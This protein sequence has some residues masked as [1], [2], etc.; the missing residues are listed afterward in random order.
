MV[1]SKTQNSDVFEA[2]PWSYGT[3]GF[4]VSATL[5]IVPC[6]KWVHI[7][8]KPCTSLAQ[9][10]RTFREAS[11]KDD[12]AQFVEALAYTKERMVVMEANMVDEEQVDA[13]K[14]NRI[15]YWYKPWFYKHVESFFEKGVSDEYIPLR[16]YY[17]RHTK[18]I[19]WELELMCP[20]GNHP[21]FRFLF[22][23]IMPPKVSFLKLTQTKA[24]Q[25][26]YEKEHVIQD[27]L[28]PIDKLADTLECFHENYELYPL[29][30]CPHRHND[31][32]GFLRRPLQPNKDGYEMYV[33]VGAYGVPQ[34]CLDKKPFD[35]V[36]KSR[37]VEAWVAQN[38]GFQMLY[39]D[40]Y[41]TKEEFEGMFDHSHY[42]AMREKLNAAIAF[43]TVFEKVRKHGF[44]LAKYE[45]SKKKNQ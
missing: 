45:A 8:Y 15:S 38:H 43:P 1:C 27:M 34:D 40:S 44:D 32:R 41:Q 3:L 10:D 18:S 7:H 6:K 30:I 13:S 20:L 16:D 17:H 14:T 5:K 33:D 36:D 25:E 2:L 37:K 26:I 21:V 9:G 42:F 35:I 23:M 4:L 12:P 24:L 39:A 29:W 31:E 11:C 28:M 22:G 19:F